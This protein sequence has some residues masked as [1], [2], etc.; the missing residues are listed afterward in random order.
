MKRLASVLT[1]FLASSPLLA[2]QIPDHDYAPPI[3]RPAHPLDTGPRVAIDEAHG[4]FHTL[5]GRYSTFAKLLSRDG[6]RV[7][8]WKETFSVD[9]LRDIDVLVIS[10][11]LH[12]SN[13][14]NWSLPTPSAFTADEITA[15]HDWVQQGG[16]LLLIA[17]HMPFPGA[18]AELASRFGVEFSNGYARTGNPSAGFDL[19]QL[20][21]GLR[22]SEVTRGR[23]DD[24]AVTEVAT[25]GGSAFKLPDGA[26]PVLVFGANSVSRET[27]KAPGIT[28]DAAVVPV[29]GW[30]QGAVLRVGQGRVA[31]FG[32][33]A[34]FSAQWAGPAKNPMGMN[35]PAA[36]QNHQLVLNVLRWLT[37]RDQGSSAAQPDA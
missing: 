32:E 1:L 15:V 4:N 31:I 13:F 30:S 2:Q 19:F 9:S 25:F 35:A 20:G 5:E 16:A 24:P 12:E 3:V 33:A 8:A 14:G 23:A 27:T 36:K 37:E 11:P 28:P 6:F 7:S 22:D 18:A 17:D 34:M 21:D 29:E 10:N 26:I